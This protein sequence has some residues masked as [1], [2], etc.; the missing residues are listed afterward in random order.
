MY[1]AA[2]QNRLID[3]ALSRVRNGQLTE[4]SLARLAGISQPHLHNV[5]KGIRKLSPEIGDRI[6][7]ALRLS[8]LDLLEA[9]EA[10][11]IPPS[12]AGQDRYTDV[13]V[14]EGRIGPGLPLPALD[15]HVERHLCR[16]DLLARVAEPRLARL[17]HDERMQPLLGPNDLVLLDLSQEKRTHLEPDGLYLVNRQ[18]QGAI[19]KLRAGAGCL[20]LLTA[21]DGY[22]P[23]TWEKVPLEG[24]SLLEIV[25][26]KVVWILRPL[27]SGAPALPAPQPSPPAAERPDLLQQARALR[28]RARSIL[29]QARMAPAD[30]SPRSGT[31]PPPD[32]S[33]APGAPS[34]PS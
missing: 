23:E 33:P 9:Q 3:A 30:F 1:F 8:V 32:R 21:Q 6:L 24:R 22:S 2:L 5:L 13:P 4:R 20:Y 14:L 29:A 17:A 10:P 12:Q 11:D 16:R 19:R 18:E 7:A 15:S 31:A 27:E 26:A 28:E 34:W 25:L